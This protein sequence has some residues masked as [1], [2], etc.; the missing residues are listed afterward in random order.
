MASSNSMKSVAKVA[1]IGLMRR[2]M[3]EAG[4]RIKWTAL[5][6]FVGKMAKVMKVNLLMTSVKVRELSSGL[7]AVSILDSGKAESST[8]RVPTLTKMVK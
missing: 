8:V 2:L 4:T 5:V 1:T 3:K 7:M 6:Y